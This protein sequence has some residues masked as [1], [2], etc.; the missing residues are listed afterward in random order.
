MEWIKLKH[1]HPDPYRKILLRIN[2][3]TIETRTYRH[4]GNT[5]VELKE[6]GFF[7]AGVGLSILDQECEWSYF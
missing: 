7:V 5:L 3:D 2:S 6:D 4:Y 1:K